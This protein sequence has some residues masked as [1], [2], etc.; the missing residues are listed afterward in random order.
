MTIGL[1]PLI[2]MIAWLPLLPREIWTIEPIGVP[3]NDKSQSTP[4]RR[5]FPLIGNVICALLIGLVLWWNLSN[6]GNSPLTNTLPRPLEYAGRAL[7]LDQH[8]QMF[9]IPPNESPWFVYDTRLKNG[10]K[11][12]IFRPGGQLSLERPDDISATFP[13]HNWRKLHQNLVD[14]RLVE[15]RST[16]LDYA[17]RR[18]NAT[19][20]DQEQVKS[21]R[22]ICVIETTGPN[23]NPINRFTITWGAYQDADAG[24][25][26]LFDDF[27]ERILKGDMP[28]F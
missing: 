10:D 9:G 1:F 16:L 6:M 13:S 14:P 26:S 28:S 22:L 3:T 18:W 27:E 25:G 17:V 24:P 19:H 21:S 12:D 11:V 5:L 23:F 20:S 4:T 7:G 8:F 2:C 15:F